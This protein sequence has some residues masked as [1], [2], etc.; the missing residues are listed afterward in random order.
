MKLMIKML[1]TKWNCLVTF[2]TVSCTR[3]KSDSFQ[4]YMTFICFTSRETFGLVPTRNPTRTVWVCSECNFSLTNEY[5]NIFVAANYSWRNFRIYSFVLIF[6][7]ECPNIFVQL[8][9]SQMNV[10]IYWNKKYCPNIF[11]Y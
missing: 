9:Y 7:N 5:P 2:L 10:Q 1:K 3:L 8:V 11:F 6:T 4:P